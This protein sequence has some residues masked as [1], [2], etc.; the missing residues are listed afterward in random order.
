M[1]LESGKPYWNTRHDVAESDLP[2][3]KDAVFCYFYHFMPL[4]RFLR[5]IWFAVVI[6]IV[7]V[8]S[9]SKFICRRKLK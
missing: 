7:V 9:L 2:P 8:E 1:K 6:N 3:K 5:F 4:N